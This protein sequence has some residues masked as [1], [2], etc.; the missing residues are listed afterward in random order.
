MH[1]T[2][3]ST[4]HLVLSL[5]PHLTKRRQLLT[6]VAISDEATESDGVEH[7]GAPDRTIPPIVTEKEEKEK[8]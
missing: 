7:N 6:Q 8:E 4:S 2:P 1:Q 3:T 5:A